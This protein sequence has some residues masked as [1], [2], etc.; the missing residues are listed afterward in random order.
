LRNILVHLLL[1]GS[2][3]GAAWAAD[4]DETKPELPR[5]EASETGE[6][7]GFFDAIDE[8]QEMLSRQVVKMGYRLD[9]F[10]G[11]DDYVRPERGSTLR[12]RGT[13]LVEED[14]TDFDSSIRLRLQLPNTERRLSLFLETGDDDDEFFDTTRDDASRTPG[15]DGSTTAGLQYVYQLADTWNFDID[16]GIRARTPLEPFVSAEVARSWFYGNGE[17]RVA[18]E[19]YWYREDGAGATIEFIAQ[20]PLPGPRFFRSD[21]E[22]TWHHDERYIAYSQDFGLWHE[23]T[24]LHAVRL[25]LGVRARSEPNDR[26]EAYFVNVRW[27]RNV[28]EDWLFVELRPELLYHRDEDFDP[29]PRVFVTLEAYFGDIRWPGVLPGEYED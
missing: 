20:A 11:G 12:I 23:F 6:D 8:R 10:F 24:P 29:Q 19:L 9:R 14:G 13:T 3:T 1:L 22:A 16:A 7:D 17:L 4:P 27:R 26:I 18:Q 28:F 5:L 15:S 25:G 21:T 2:A